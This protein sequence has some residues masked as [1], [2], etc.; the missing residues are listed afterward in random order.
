MIWLKHGIT[1]LDIRLHSLQSLAAHLKLLLDSSE[2]LW[3]LMEKKL[4]LHA[5][6]LFL[7]SRV[8]HRSLLRHG[9]EEDEEGG[10]ASLGIDISVSSGY[11]PL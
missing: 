2:H 7:L 3:R 8:V 6:W 1:L 9:E 11:I 5:A 10:W 4:Y